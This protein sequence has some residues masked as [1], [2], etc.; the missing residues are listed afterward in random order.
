MT[1]ASPPPS[2]P[3]HVHADVLG[4][5]AGLVL[6]QNQM[7]NL[8]NRPEW[9]QGVDLD[10]LIAA[11]QRLEGCA[12]RHENRALAPYLAAI[13]VFACAFTA[14]EVFARLNGGPLS[15]GQAAQALVLAT[16]LAA[17]IALPLYDIR[18]RNRRI[19]AA[20]EQRLAEV[21]V[22]IAVRTERKPRLGLMARLRK[23]ERTP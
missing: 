16:V 6:V 5:V 10:R 11:Q 14:A 19:V 9:I 21:V 17:G 22:E 3:P 1:E 20:A 18:R 7:V 23:A 15:N 8:G 2:P 13:A 12:L 4:N